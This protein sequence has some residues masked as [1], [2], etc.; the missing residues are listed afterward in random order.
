MSYSNLAAQ[1]SM[2]FDEERNRAYLAAMRACIG[3]DTVVL[4]VGAGLGVL[5]LLAAK[6]GARHVYCVEPSPVAAHIT[7][8]A[9]ANGVGDRI[10][11]LQA[12]IEA[13]QLP[14]QVD[15]ILS[16]FT[17]NLLFTEDLLPSLYHARDRWLKPGGVLLPDRARLHLCAAEAADAH[18]KSVARYEAPSLG[19]DY[20]ALAATA[21][22]D[23]IAWQRSDTAP[24]PLTPVVQACELDF[25]TT[26]ADGVNFKATTTTTCAGTLHALLGWIEIRLGDRWLS[27]AP[28][29]P[30]VHWSPTL[31]PFRVPM[32]VQAGEEVEI[33]LRYIDNDQLFWTLGCNGVQ[34]RQSPL[35]GNAQAMANLM[36]SSP[37]R[38]GPLSEQGALLLEALQ[39]MAAGQTNATIAQHLLEQ[40]PRRFSD[41]RQALRT[42][43]R[44]AA[45][46][47][48]RP[49]KPG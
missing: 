11:V 13:V 21:A 45:G 48:E 4:D 26:T 7:A 19:I 25:H 43:G 40:Y 1:A 39:A 15:V 22:N 18:A 16:V 10:T 31:L 44:W 46:Y 28:D 20:A 34:Q 8:L 41:L 2:V 14:C 17:G 24:R 27:T 47:R 49:N 36:L 37:G 33:G 30:A 29:Q 6:A 12:P 32:D 35:Q 5:G 9:Q 3:P 38:C 42:V 23:L